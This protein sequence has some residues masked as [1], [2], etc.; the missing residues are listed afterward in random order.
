MRPPIILK[1]DE[2]LIFKTVSDAERHFEPADYFDQ[3][4]KAYDSEGLLLELK[5]TDAKKTRILGVTCFSGTNVRLSAG[6]SDASHIQALKAILRDLLERY[7]VDP[8]WLHE[9]SLRELLGKSIEHVGF[10]T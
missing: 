8:L 2:V 10:S 1:S 3:D 9:A 4:L 6:D 5:S 7:N